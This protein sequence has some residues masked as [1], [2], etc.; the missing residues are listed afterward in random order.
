M[1]SVHAVQGSSLSP[2]LTPDSSSPRVISGQ[3][4]RIPGVTIPSHTDL[5]MQ[6]CCFDCD[7]F[8]L[9]KYLGQ[10]HTEADWDLGR[11]EGECRFNPPVIGPEI[12][13]DG[14]SVRLYGEFSLV[15]ATD[16]CGQF[17]SQAI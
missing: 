9:D 15:L 1:N 12:E 6:R 7:Y 14:E 10:E 8:Q 2:F 3:K 16:W 5:A 11:A 4:D 17:Q 13:R